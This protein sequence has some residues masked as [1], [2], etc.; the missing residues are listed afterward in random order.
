P[1]AVIDILVAGARRAVVSTGRLEGPRAL[2]RAFRLTPELAV[3]IEVGPDG[4]VLGDPAWGVRPQAAAEA[5]RSC[6]IT[7][8]I[9]SPRPGPVD[10]SL[11]RSI[12]EGG[13]LWIDGSFVA[14]EAPRLSDC[15]ASGGFFHVADEIVP[16]SERERPGSSAR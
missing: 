1:D 2:A 15:G 11:A 9:L 4:T 13:S 3:E 16:F 12:S 10:W 7:E 6:G 8:L 5:A 14:A